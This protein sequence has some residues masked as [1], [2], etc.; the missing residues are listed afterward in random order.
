MQGKTQ[1]R[2]GLH[3]L[4][5]ILESAE[6]SEG[7]QSLSADVANFKSELSMLA[8]LVAKKNNSIEKELLRLHNLIADK[9]DKLEK[10]I[11]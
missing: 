4:K 11:E 6:L 8:E 3:E 10:K 2:S 5:Q 7:Q 1:D 9:I